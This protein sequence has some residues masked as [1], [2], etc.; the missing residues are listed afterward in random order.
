MVANALLAGIKLTAGLLGHS[1]ALVADAIESM[2]DVLSSLVVWR[3]L[4][5][6]AEPEDEDHPYGH[7]KA[8]PIAAA[9]VATMLLVAATWIVTTAF[10]EVREPHQPIAPFT[11]IV[12]GAVI[13]VKETLFRFVLRESDSVDS[14]AVRADAWHHRSDAITSL[15]AAVGI[16][17]SLVGGRGYESADNFAAMA[18]AIVIAANGW[19]MLRPALS[20]LMDRSP[21]GEMLERIRAIAEAAPGVDRVEKCVARKMGYFYYVDMHIEVDPQMTVQRSHDIAHG[22]KDKIRSQIP[23]VRDVLVHVEPAVKRVR[24]D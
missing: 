11:L 17:I 5:V 23:R 12:L 21:G 18:A 9:G 22:V 3:G 1:Q 13:A 2:A 10:R 8:E 4:V 7:G 19:R 20:E 14:P 16:T 15:S 6:A 24:R